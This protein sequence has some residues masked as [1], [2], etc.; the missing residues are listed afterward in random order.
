MNGIPF[1]ADSPGELDGF[2][3]EYGYIVDFD[4]QT[5]EFWSLFGQPEKD[6]YKCHPVGKLSWDDLKN[7]KRKIFTGVS[8]EHEENWI[9]EEEGEMNVAQ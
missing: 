3:C 8:G 2:Y 9:D 4:N 6:F 7:W 5:I 1:A